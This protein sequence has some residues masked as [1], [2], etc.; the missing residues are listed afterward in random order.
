MAPAIETTC[1]A[2]SLLSQVSRA[3]THDDSPILLLTYAF[4]VRTIDFLSCVWGWCVHAFGWVG[5]SVCGVCVCV[6]R[7]ALVAF[8]ISAHVTL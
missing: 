6:F 1:G 7:A 8:S 5:V 3:Y 4:Q 2:L